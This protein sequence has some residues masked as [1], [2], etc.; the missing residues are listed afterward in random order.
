MEEWWDRDEVN[1][2]A[3]LLDGRS[4]AAFSC[5]CRSVSTGLRSQETLRW[6]ASLR[7]LA[8]DAGIHSIEHL[9][10]A[11]VMAE[12]ATSIFFGWGSFDVDA[13]AHPSLRRLARILAR[14]KSLTLSI[15]AHCGL[16]ALYAMPLAGQARS[17]TRE[18][19]GAVRVALEAQ[20]CAEGVPLDDGR[21]QT[22]AWGCSRP[23]VYCFGQR[24]MDNALFDPIGAAKNRRVE[25]YLRGVGFEVPTRRK[26]SE[27]PRPPNEAPLS[28]PPDG[29]LDDND[30]DGL[31]D[32]G[33]AST[34]MI[35]VVLPNGQ[36]VQIP[37]VLLHQLN[38]DQLA[39][40]SDEEEEEEHEEEHGEDEAENDDDDGE[41][42]ATAA[43]EQDLD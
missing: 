22:R 30:D 27:I 31:A 4:L 43:A 20:A 10:I 5:S 14:H 36:R 23:M 38:F 3:V 25:L 39:L 16:E 13:S 29:A 9:E 35:N 17:F 24:G 32:A 2:I 21:V 15:E 7:G 12:C 37:P 40:G 6:L 1:L 18:R 33:I 19:A 34:E 26:R 41:V 28:E 11:E 42:V 8:S